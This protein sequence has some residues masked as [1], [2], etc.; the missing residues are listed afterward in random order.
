[1][2]EVGSLRLALI[3]PTPMSCERACRAGS[4]RR[5]RDRKRREAMPGSIITAKALTCRAI[6]AIGF[7]GPFFARRSRRGSSVSGLS[8]NCYRNL[9][10]VHNCGHA[11]VVRLGRRRPTNLSPAGLLQWAARL[12]LVRMP[13]TR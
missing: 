10:V 11:Q 9:R 2:I 12:R 13:H 1:M 6:A 4:P 8:S 3:I 5:P 7:E